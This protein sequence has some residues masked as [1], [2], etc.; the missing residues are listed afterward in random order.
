MKL[1]ASL[2]V[3]T[4]SA[5]TACAAQS[6][7][8]SP[9]TDAPGATG[10]QESAWDAE[11]ADHEAES[12]HLWIVDRALDVLAKHQDDESAARAVALLND[13]TCQASWHQGLLDADFKAAYNGGRSDLPLNPND[14][15]VA[16][17]GATWE[18]HFFDPD[19]GKNY[20]G[21]ST[22]TA[23]TEASSHIERAFE[24][25]LGEGGATACY[26]LGLALHYFTDLTQPMHAS[27]FTAVDRPAKL[28]SNLEG[29]SKEIQDR[30]PL[31][32]WTGAPSGTVA[33]FVMQ[34][35]K[36][37]KPLFQDGVVAI[38]NAYKA[39]R[40]IHILTC[41]NIDAEPW[42]FIERQHLDYKYCWSGNP[43]VDAMVGKTL[44]SAQ[45]HT[46]KYLYLVA[47]RIGAEGG[48]Q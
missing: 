30:Y 14:A 19:T 8:D 36:D 27:N 29:Y 20:K 1:R 10:A 43:G 39:Y 32:D 5:L 37:S 15:Q 48:S 7:A 3:L 28:H 11:S 22:N 18:S 6:D 42:R 33:D 2:L 25:H 40:G 9:A 17:A 47:E 21:S 4:L 44:E 45:D 41:R 13:P 38:V 46:A 24:N 16:I 26:E 35:A 12:T 34:T 31:A 23:F